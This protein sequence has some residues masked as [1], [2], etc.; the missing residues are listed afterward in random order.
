MINF[1]HL[2]ALLQFFYHIYW[3]RSC[4][5]RMFLKSIS[6]VGRRQNIITL[7]TVRSDGRFKRTESPVTYI[8][9]ALRFRK[10]IGFHCNANPLSNVTNRRNQEVAVIATR[11]IRSKKKTPFSQGCFIFTCV[12]RS[13]IID[14]TANQSWVHWPNKWAYWVTWS[15]L[16]ERSRGITLLMR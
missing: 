16:V 5:D 12:R 14:A 15:S 2:K 7:G 9:P 1:L 13:S 6:H 10:V 3:S 4:S 8:L 11:L